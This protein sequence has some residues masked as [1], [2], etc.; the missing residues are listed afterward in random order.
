MSWTLKMYWSETTVWLHCDAQEPSYN[1]MSWGAVSL[2]ENES[3]LYQFLWEV[4]NSRA[5]NKG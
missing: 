3:C 4:V 2:E 5:G 1:T